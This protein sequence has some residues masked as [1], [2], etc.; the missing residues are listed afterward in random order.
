MPDPA[1]V[2]R[3]IATLVRPGGKVFVSTINRNP[4]AYLMM[5]LGAEYLMKMVPRVPTT[6]RSSSP[7]PNCVAWVRQ[8]A[9]WYGT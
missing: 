9:C 6:T 8:Q 5:I 1:S 2:L 4:K 3:A 7:P